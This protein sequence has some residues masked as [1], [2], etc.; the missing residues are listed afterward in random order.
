MSRME[1]AETWNQGRNV[2]PN[3]GRLMERLDA[4]RLAIAARLGLTV[5][6]IFEHFHRSFHVPID[7]IAAM[8]QAMAARG[9]GGTG[10]ATADSRYVTEDVPYGLVP[11]VMLGE[12]AG[13]PASL[14]RAGVE[15][16]SAMYGRDFAAENTLLA[17]L[18]LP[19]RSLADLRAASITGR[20]PHR[21]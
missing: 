4:E 3:L 1:Q 2:T 15:I 20:L 19:R 13:R 16:F 14:H 21:A 18:D 10:P 7:S 9:T 6:T 5:K 8:N 17:A 11:T 12:L